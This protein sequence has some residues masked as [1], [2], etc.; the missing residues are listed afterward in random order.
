MK[1]KPASRNRSRSWPS[2]TST[3][4]LAKKEGEKT[5]IEQFRL[6][7]SRTTVVH[8]W[9]S[10]V[11]KRKFRLS[12]NFSLSPLTF[13]GKEWRQENGRKKL[14]AESY[15]AFSFKIFLLRSPWWRRNL[16]ARDYTEPLFVVLSGGVRVD[17]V[18]A[19][20]MSTALP[21]ARVSAAA[22]LSISILVCASEILF[23]PGGWRKSYE[24]IIW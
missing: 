7:P 24:T 10:F 3:N 22:C 14:I 17:C 21:S 4:S 13:I 16:C 18:F 8:V 11:G 5:K 23:A 12:L 2:S 9:K 1:N 20:R 15:Y 6:L 19:T